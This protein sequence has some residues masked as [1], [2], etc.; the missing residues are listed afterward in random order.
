VKGLAAPLLAVVA[1]T[2]AL[3]ART[4][5]Y[6]WSYLDD[7]ELVVGELA[8][9]SQ[10]G[11]AAKAF[12]RPY[13]QGR[14]RD[15][16]YYRPVVTASFALDAAG[17]GDVASGY[18]AT[19]VLLHALA[20][21]LLL[22]VLVAEGYSRGL[23]LLVT[24]GFVAH[25]ALTATV[26]WIP[27][28]DDLLLGLFSL[29]AWLALERCGRGTR[30]LPAV[31][32]GA[33][34]FLAL[35]SKETAIALPFVFAL[36]KLVVARQ[37]LATAVPRWLALT[38]LA[39]VVTVALARRSV[40]GSGLGLPAVGVG[41]LLGGGKALLTGL[42]SLLVPFRPQ[43]LA[44]SGDVPLAP[45]CLA[46]ALLLAALALPG[47][48]RRRILV[49]LGSYAALSLPSVPASSVLVLESRLYLPAVALSLGIAEIARCLPLPN[50][51]RPALGAGVV[52]AAASLAW[53]TLG[54][55]A[56]RTT[57]ARSLSRGSPHSAL[58]Q[59]NLG[60]AE[61][62][63]GNAAAARRAYQRALAADPREPLVHNNLA[64]LL[65]AEG[66]LAAAEQELLTELTLHP[67]SSEARQ[68]LVRIHQALGKPQNPS[69][70]P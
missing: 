60:V 27:G 42:G 20:G 6:P 11:A 70:F 8:V 37:P 32:H 68:N 57:F 65:M 31:V 64:V 51:A 35:A 16:A 41:E 55:Y 62:L 67:N 12:G 2:V 7:Q 69:L 39:A 23:S 3:Y 29:A 48:S 30:A 36:R 50:G 1:L 40:L 5:A 13:F 59:R 21:C 15:H 26:A 44:V 19:N 28:R 38:W 49:A 56:D 43:F 63:S 34:F 9:L 54:D 25:P 17:S 24:L 10:P 4:L 53:R 58:A 66:N 18:R 61:Q 52:V 22:L 46:L 14:E 45:G 47:V 33:A